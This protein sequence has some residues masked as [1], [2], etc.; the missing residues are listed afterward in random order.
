MGILKKIEEDMKNT[1]EDACLRLGKNSTDLTFL[2]ST[3]L[4]GD[5]QVEENQIGQEKLMCH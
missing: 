1:G 4:S 2:K 5:L 3:L